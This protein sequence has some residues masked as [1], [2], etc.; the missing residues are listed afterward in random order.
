M[1]QEYVL[2][3]LDNFKETMQNKKVETET[4]AWLTFL[5]CDEPDRIMELI[6]QYPE[7]EAMYQTLYQVCLN[8]E[9]VM[10]M[11]S[12]ELYELDRNTIK[13]MIEEQQEKLDALN[14]E[15]LEKC[16]EIE[17]T[18]EKLENS[19]VEL[20]NSKTELENSKAELESSK[21]ELENS[22]AE[23]ESSKSELASQK[24][25]IASQQ[26]ALLEK[27]RVIEKLK[28]RLADLGETI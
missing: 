13:L 19:K 3:A 9:R 28:E 23:L 4:E 18:E 15:L 27:D 7:F 21:A 20:K 17:R 16:K 22:K 5:S 26:E 14:A 2:I 25:E 6:Q 1:L 12:E 10:A 8:I 11:F 24:A